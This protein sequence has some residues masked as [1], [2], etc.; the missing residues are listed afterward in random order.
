MRLGERAHLLQAAESWRCA[1]QHPHS[2]EVAFTVYSSSFVVFLFGIET[3]FLCSP[4]CPA[5]HY[6]ELHLVLAS[7]SQ[8][9]ACFCL[10]SAGIN[11]VCH[12]PPPGFQRFLQRLVLG[13]LQAI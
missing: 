9:S 2:Q 11:R 1:G 5:A 3:V 10:C 6:G 12:L 7:S 13:T 4:G 8:R